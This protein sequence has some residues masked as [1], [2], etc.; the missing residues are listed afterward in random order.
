MV[1]S[2]QVPRQ[3][4]QSICC[5]CSGSPFRNTAQPS[6]A[7]QLNSPTTP[8]ASSRLRLPWL[9]VRCDSSNRQEVV[10]LSLNKP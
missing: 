6:V 2:D 7:H 4:T 1:S 8:P 9:L 5:C 10:T 3:N